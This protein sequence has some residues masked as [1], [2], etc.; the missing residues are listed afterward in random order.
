MYGCN[1]TGTQANDAPAGLFRALARFLLAGHRVV[2]LKGNHDMNWFWPEV[3]YRFLELMQD[4]L[5][6]G[7][8][9]PLRDE[10]RVASVLERIEIRPWVYYVRNLLYVGHGNQYAPVN[11]FLD[12][13]PLADHDLPHRELRIHFRRTP[14][15]PSLPQEDL[16]VLADRITA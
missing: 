14:L 15:G 1:S 2:I 11:A 16:P 13:P 7:M 6:E 5:K 4:H 8:Q 3:R 9:D 10:A 12:E